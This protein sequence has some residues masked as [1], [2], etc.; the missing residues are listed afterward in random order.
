VAPPAPPAPPPVAP[1]APP[2]VPTGSVAVAG[3]AEAGRTVTASWTGAD[4][5]ITTYQWLLCDQDGKA[6]QPLAGETNQTYV[7]KV[8]DLG[9]TVRVAAVCGTYSSTSRATDQIEQGG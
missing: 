3:K 9:K 5:A 8:A 1:P 6:C 4:P 2:L 7:L